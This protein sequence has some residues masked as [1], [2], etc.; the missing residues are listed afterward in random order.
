MLWSDDT[1]LLFDCGLKTQRDLEAI[2]EHHLPYLRPVDA[3]IVSHSHVDHI[4]YPAL[5]VFQRR[6]VAIHGHDRVI[7]QVRERYELHS[8]PAAPHLYSFSDSAFQIGD[9][10]IRPIEVDH[11][12]GIPNFAFVVGHGEANTRRTMVICTD[13]NGCGALPDHLA[14]ADFVFIESNH[15]PELLRLFPNYASR[16]HMSNPRT[17]RLLCEAY[18]LR[19]R[20]PRLVMLGHLSRQRNRAELALAAV[21]EAFASVGRTMP[22]ELRTAP[23]YEPS[24]TI[25]V[26]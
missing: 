2:L 18:A 9:L 4:G 17:A 7:R 8:W 23:L 12:P 26:G 13:F 24:E 1:T 14:G 15:D 6:S 3:V 11:E 16:F 19:E 20:T 25:E 21:R 10:S 22:F 5:R